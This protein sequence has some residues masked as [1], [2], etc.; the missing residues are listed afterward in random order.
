MNWSYVA[1]FFDG[2]G[3]LLFNPPLR[4]KPWVKSCLGMRITLTQKSS[5]VLHELKAFLA[6]YSIE[7]HVRSVKNPPAFRLEV[8]SVASVLEIC[9]T[10]YPYLIVKKQLVEDMLRFNQLFPAPRQRG[11]ARRPIRRHEPRSQRPLGP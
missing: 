10:L 2:E 4:S 5:P 9:Q 1:G 7:A 6:G 3:S 11:N 8:G